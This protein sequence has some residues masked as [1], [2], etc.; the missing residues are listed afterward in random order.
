MHFKFQI[1]IVRRIISFILIEINYIV[2]L[3]LVTLNSTYL[4]DIYF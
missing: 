4:I 2:R 3:T 1:R